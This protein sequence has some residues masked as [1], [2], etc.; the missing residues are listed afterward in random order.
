MEVRK[1]VIGVTIA[2]TQ[3]RWVWPAVSTLVIFA[4]LLS[5]IGCPSPH[6]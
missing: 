3:S 1:A 5:V 2:V 4:T 6:H